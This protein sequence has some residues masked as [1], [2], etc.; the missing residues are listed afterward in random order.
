MHSS[1]QMRIFFAL[2][3]CLISV[4]CE[5]RDP[6]KDVELPITSVECVVGSGSQGPFVKRIQEFAEANEFAIRI[7]HPTQNPNSFTIQLWRDDI[8]MVAVNSFSLEQFEIFLYPLDHEKSDAEMA[9]HLSRSLITSIDRA[10]SCKIVI[11]H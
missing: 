3:F 7:G 1:M 6:E 5:A 10:G 9:D 4:G 11:P 2:T 8:K